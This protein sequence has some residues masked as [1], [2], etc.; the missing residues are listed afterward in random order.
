MGISLHRL[1]RFINKMNKIR[2]IKIRK[3]KI[4]KIKIRKIKISKLYPLSRTF[5][6]RGEPNFWT[7]S[8]S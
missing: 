1:D 8:L 2:K 3:I 4:R 7:P 5:L 6:K